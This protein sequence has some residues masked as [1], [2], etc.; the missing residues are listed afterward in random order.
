MKSERAA[1][2]ASCIC[3]GSSGYRRRIRG[4]DE[5]RH[6]FEILG[7]PR[8]LGRL[9]QDRAAITSERPGLALR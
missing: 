5:P 8:L 7:A 4:D 6:K 9:R 1:R 3:V 2:N